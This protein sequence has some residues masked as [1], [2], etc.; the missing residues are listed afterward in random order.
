MSREQDWETRL[1]YSYL[2]D[3]GVEQ[4][5]Q[6]FLSDRQL[7]NLIT[8]STKCNYAR[9]QAVLIE[10]LRI[11]KHGECISVFLPMLEYRR[12]VELASMPEEYSYDCGD[13]CLSLT[14]RGEEIVSENLK[15]DK[16]RDEVFKGVQTYDH[17]SSILP[18]AFPEVECVRTLVTAIKLHANH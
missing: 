7:S 2:K 11:H 16:I 1:N 6:Y 5:C 9:D 17:R 10:L 3:K 12:W 4:D 13:R 18:L 14:K 15:D 8:R